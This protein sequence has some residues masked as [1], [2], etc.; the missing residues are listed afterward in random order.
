M[1]TPFSR[2]YLMCF[3]SLMVPSKVIVSYMHTCRTN[4]SGSDEAVTQCIGKRDANKGKGL[5]EAPVFH[6]GLEQSL[7]CFLS[8]MVSSQVKMSYM[9]MGRTSFSG[10]DEDVKH[11]IENAGCEKGNQP[12]P[13]KMFTQTSEQCSMFLPSLMLKLSSHNIETS[14]ELN[15]VCR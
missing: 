4:F 15:K 1:F 3:P 11:G 14:H 10:S 9:H 6:A 2:Q 8:L 13:G 12:P 5:P 7:M